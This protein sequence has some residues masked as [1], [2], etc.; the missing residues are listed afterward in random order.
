ME[1]VCRIREF[2]DSDINFLMSLRN[3][4]ELQY[5]LITHPK[6]NSTEQ[7]KN[8]IMNKI[9]SDKTIFFVIASPDN[10]PIGFI[11]ASDIDMVNRICKIGL[12]I[13]NEW[14]RRGVFKR[15]ISDMENYLSGSMNIRK[16]V[17]EILCVNESSRKA[18]ESVGYEMAGILKSHYYNNGEYHDIVIYEKFTST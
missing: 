2:L 18:F 17:A 11:Q 4:M 3:D 12:A 6:P 10:K 7:V 1:L 14:R 9:N 8:W 5:L 15:V 16:I 13:E